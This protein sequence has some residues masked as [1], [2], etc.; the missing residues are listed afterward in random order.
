[1]RPTSLGI[2]AALFYIVLLAAFFA[3]PYANLFFLLLAFLTIQA[4]VSY[5]ACRR[6]L[7]GVRAI[8]DELDPVPAHTGAP[9][10]VTLHGGNRTRFA[11]GIRL[12][13]EDQPPLVLAGGVVKGETR[14][15]G[16]VPPLPRGVY[17]VKR[18]SLFTTWPLGLYRLFTP[19]RAPAELVVY[20]APA[21]L[22]GEGNAGI[23][24]VY[25]ALGGEGFLQPSALR[26]YRPGDE[27]R[28]VAWKASARRGSFVIKE[29]EGGSGAG[30]EAVLDRRT[31]PESLEQALSLLSALS[32]AAKEQ[33]DLLTLHSQGL[34]A[35]FGRQR[36]PWR[37]LL[38]FLARAEALPA[39][40]PAPPAVSPDVLRLPWNPGGA[41]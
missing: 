22:T 16:R 31:D 11:L 5:V 2:K 7:T 37:E 1:V 40:A 23:G 27:L 39:D 10:S 3:A 14:V 41:A 33:K 26:E 17:P 38:T 4:L 21:Q 30:H 19:V 35:T 9:V 15:A 34:S 6:N 36:R 8:V 28:L 29:W 18:A 12:E 13:L 25:S 20:P 24:D 32:L